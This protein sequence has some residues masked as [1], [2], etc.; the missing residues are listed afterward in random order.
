[1]QPRR[2]TLPNQGDAD[3]TVAPRDLPAVSNQTVVFCPI[4]IGPL[5][6]F[7]EFPKSIEA[8]VSIP[9]LDST[10]L[11]DDATLT[12]TIVSADALVPPALP[13]LGLFMVLDPAS[14]ASIATLEITGA[15]GVGA[16]AQ[17]LR[18]ALW[19]Q[20]HRRYVGAKV[21]SGNGIGDLS[22]LWGRFQ[23]VS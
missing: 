19:T 6:P 2:S 1:M 17:E 3:L 15:D 9:A 13:V 18:V 23:I 4:D 22:A 20:P 5:S 21:T 8:V 10:Q 14:E 11:P 12:V 16:P 7:A